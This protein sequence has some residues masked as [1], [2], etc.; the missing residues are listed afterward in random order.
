MSKSRHRRLSPALVISVIALFVAIGG[1]AGA[2]PGK[3]SVDSGDIKKNAVKS[4]DISNKKGV[5]SPD[6]VDDGLTGR[7]I[8]ESSLFGVGRANKSNAA[9][10]ADRANRLDVVRFVRSQVVVVAVGADESAVANCPQPG[11]FASGGGGT[12]PAASG[13]QVLRSVPS[14]GTAGQAG[15]T[16]WEFRVRNNSGVARN[17]RAYAVCVP[18]DDAT[19]NYAPGNAVD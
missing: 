12:Y 3:N 9:N 13:V 16:A 19:G 18:V 14:N 4:V 2:L 5:K 11:T 10:T 1:V 15:F 17:L 6:V 8:R 7:D